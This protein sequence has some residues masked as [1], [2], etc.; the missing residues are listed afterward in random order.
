MN[1]CGAGQSGTYYTTSGQGKLLLEPRYDRKSR[2]RLLTCT[3]IIVKLWFHRFAEN[4]KWSD[5]K[6]SHS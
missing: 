2:D 3:M 5:E 4:N 6:E 1:K